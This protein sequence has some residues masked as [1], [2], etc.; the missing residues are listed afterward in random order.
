MVFSDKYNHNLFDKETIS[1]GGCRVNINTYNRSKHFFF[2]LLLIMTPFLISFN[3]SSASEMSSF[4]KGQM[5]MIEGIP[6]L[7]LYGNYYEMGLQ[8]GYLLKD[9]LLEIHE[10]I[11][12]FKS[13]ISVGEFY[14]HLQSNMPDKYKDF[15]AGVSKSTAI[16]YEDLL[17]GSFYEFTIN[18]CSSILA[19]INFHGSVFLLHA[20]NRDTSNGKNQLIIEFNPEK[21]YMYIV[22]ATTGALFIHEGVNEKGISITG[23]AAPPSSYKVKY[24]PKD[25]IYRMIL[26]SAGSLSEVDQIINNYKSDYAEI[27]TIGSASENNGAIYDIGNLKRVKHEMLE[28]KYLFVTNKFLSDDLT[29]S[30]IRFSCPRYRK[31]SDLVKIKPINSV[32]DLID[33]LATSPINNINTINSIIFN[34]KKKESYFAF[35][36]GYAARTKWFKYDWTNDE[37]VFLRR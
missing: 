24:L 25:D 23:N 34:A 29:P 36:A 30:N 32:D 21:E 3:S 22:T 17:I 16:S 12:P 8:Y 1:F 28:K 15:L 27:I 35:S 4:D 33:L 31:I 18:E 9:T 13:K 10:K 20:K 6:F 11:M 7:K 26:E 14:Q 2:I 37:F 5:R 19:K